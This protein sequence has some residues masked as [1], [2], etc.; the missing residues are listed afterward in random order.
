MKPILVLY[1]IIL[2]SSL[3]TASEKP[4]II[5]LLTD[6][7]SF[8]SMGIYGNKDVQTP[9]MD[10]LGNDGIIFDRHYATTAICM[11][12]RATI[13]TGMFEYKTGCNF[14]HGGLSE[15]AF[16][17]S[18]PSLLRK[19]GYFTGFAGKFG[20]EGIAQPEDHFDRWG[21]GPNQTSFKTERNKSMK[22]YAKDFPHSTLSYGA[23]ARDF[24]DE[25][26]Q[27]NKAFCLS[28]SFKAP[29]KPATPD[30]KFNHIYKTT[31]FTKPA[32]YGRQ[33]GQHLSIQSQQGRQYERFESWNYA[34]MYQEVM[35]LYHQQ[36]YAVDVVI[37]QIR[38]QLKELQLE[39]NTVII[40]SSDNGFLCGSHGY[41][42]KVLPY[43]ESMRV[44][45]M[46]YDPRLDSQKQGKRISSLSGNCDIA[47][48]ILKLADLPIPSN[49]DGLSLLS[50]L[51]DPNIQLHNSLPLIN[52]WGPE[53]THFLGTVTTKWKYILWAY[54][55]QGM[56]VTEELFN[57]QKD[58][59]E[60]KNEA[61]NPEHSISLKQMRK[62]YDKHLAKWRDE[63][64]P[65]ND[66]QRFGKLFDRHLPW[67]KK[68]KLWTK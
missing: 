16:S 53:A 61:I 12:S 39:E 13:M 32:N 1:S 34:D 68:D 18:Y 26:K 20:I 11:A 57:M 15:E 31:Q 49:M 36:I 23:F 6:D 60:L 42:S 27:L 24:I 3:L 25:A 54:E 50:A 58:S 62:L 64:H 37:G 17:I 46:I 19:A 65:E 44:P 33:N 35:S 63:A 5:F 28:I 41:G 7:Q 22:E 4:N 29:H 55:G 43:E 47:P 56:K 30:P 9:Q 67:D 2:L 59:I 52:V 38:K 40:F 66:Y 21:G 51:D 14:K 8:Y 48:T 10:R 45:L